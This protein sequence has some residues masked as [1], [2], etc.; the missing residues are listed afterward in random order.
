V[1]TLINVSVPFLTVVMLFAV[2]LD[3]TLRPL[4][5]TPMGRSADGAFMGDTKQH[6]EVHHLL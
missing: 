1:K 2:G 4:G 3:L 5:G 6:C